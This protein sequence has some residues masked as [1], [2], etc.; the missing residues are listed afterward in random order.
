M[1]GGGEDPPPE[2]RILSLYD[3]HAETWEAMR[4][5]SLAERP[6]LERFREA[7]PKG[8]VSGGRAVLDLGCG[9]G[10]PIAAWLIAQGLRVTGIDGAPAMIARAR[11]LFPGH[12]WQVA[13]MRALPPLGPFDGLIAWNSF[14]HLTPEDQA[15]LFPAF[16]R[17][18][19]PGAPLMFTSGTER[20]SSLGTF[21]GA[22]LYHGSLATAEYRAALDAAGF[23]VLRHVESDPDC[24]GLTIWLARRR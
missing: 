8:A 22:P 11:A 9:T 16:A 18:T 15:P 13:D 4:G 19:R 24:G 21:Q 10:R 20:G 2:A 23:D 3:S 17:L 7:M 14:F 1:G 6:W 5:M 12:D